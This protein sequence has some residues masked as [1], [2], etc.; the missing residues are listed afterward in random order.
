MTQDEHNNALT[1]HNKDMAIVEKR[2]LKYQ[3]LSFVMSLITMLMVGVIMAVIVAA[4]LYVKPMITDIYDGTMRS[5]DNL[6]VLTEDLNKELKAADLEGTVK[7]V[8]ELTLQ[9]TGDL[10]DA[11]ER[12]NSIDL[13][14]LNKAIDNLNA[15]VEPLARFFR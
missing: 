11:M 6:E 13:E 15:T 9:A 1:E 5:L 3:K 10:S 8:N 2:Q 14:T 7:N 4:V 12:L